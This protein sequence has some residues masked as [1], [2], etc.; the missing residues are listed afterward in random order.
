MLLYPLNAKFQQILI[1]HLCSQDKFVIGD[2][3]NIKTRLKNT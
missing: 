1:D 2:D 3:R